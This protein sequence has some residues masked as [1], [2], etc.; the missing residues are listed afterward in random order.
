MHCVSIGS[1]QSSLYYHHQNSHQNMWMRME[2]VQHTAKKCEA[3]FP[4]VRCKEVKYVAISGSSQE[5]WLLKTKCTLY[6]IDIAE[7]FV[8]RSIC[9]IA[10]SH[11][12]W[13]CMYVCTQWI[14][15]QHVMFA[16]CFESSRVTLL[17]FS[18]QNVFFLNKVS[19]TLLLLLLSYIMSCFTSCIHKI[20]DHHR[21]KIVKTCKR[22]NETK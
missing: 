18:N 21:F 5:N 6:N 4:A 17:Y 19:C 9:G 3:E 15:I 1:N 2:Y 12:Y 22:T 14:C 20:L 8:Y 16:D 13:I 10:V 11:S 7:R